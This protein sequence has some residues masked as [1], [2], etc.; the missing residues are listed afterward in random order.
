MY[1]SKSPGITGALEMEHLLTFKGM[2]IQFLHLQTTSDIPLLLLCALGHG[3][4]AL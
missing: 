2:D 1:H 4:G 3:S